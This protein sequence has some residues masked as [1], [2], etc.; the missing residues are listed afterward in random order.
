[1]CS[2]VC[3]CISHCISVLPGHWLT[4]GDVLGLFALWH[5]VT[6]SILLLLSS[7]E[8]E[9]LNVI[10]LSFSSKMMFVSA[11]CISFK[12]LEPSVLQIAPWCIWNEAA[13]FLFVHMLAFLFLETPQSFLS[14][15][16]FF[17]FTF[18]LTRLVCVCHI[19]FSPPQFTSEYPLVLNASIYPNLPLSFLLWK[20]LYFN[21]LRHVILRKPM[22]THSGNFS[23]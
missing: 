17:F 10:F 12:L 2:L 9:L 18:H 8:S 14:F 7:K 23:N 22:A 20:E 3:S 21:Q 19:V 11:K 4:A 15:S 16:T 5:S 6:N 13:K 1:M